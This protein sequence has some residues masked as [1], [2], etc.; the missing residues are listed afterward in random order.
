MYTTTQFRITSKVYGDQKRHFL[1][2]EKSV[3]SDGHYRIT[4]HHYGVL[5]EARKECNHIL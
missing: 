2:Q 3:P 1:K 4:A 5:I